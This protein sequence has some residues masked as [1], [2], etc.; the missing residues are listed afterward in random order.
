METLVA[1]QLK[2]LRSRRGLTQT[3]LAKLLG[4][5]FAS[6]SRWEN[7]LAAPSRLAVEQI[8]RMEAEDHAPAT[9]ARAVGPVEA[10]APIGQVL[11]TFCRG[12]PIPFCASGRRV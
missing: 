4:V 10:L 11:P 3:D 6:V 12:T 2:A 1:N 8:Q 7:G 5:S 9:A